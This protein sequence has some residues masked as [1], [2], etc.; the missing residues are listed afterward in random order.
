MALKLGDRVRETTA[1]TGTGNI[2]LGGAVAG[3]TSFS[4]VLSN[5]DTTFYAMIGSNQW[6][7]M[8]LI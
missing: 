7:H 3:F 1:T 6:E 2:T 4:S 5:S 8:R